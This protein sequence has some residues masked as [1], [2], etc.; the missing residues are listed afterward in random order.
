MEYRNKTA[1]KIIRILPFLLIGVVSIVSAIILAWISSG[2]VSIQ[3]WG[4]FLVVILVA[5]AIMYG[6]WLAVKS[7]ESLQLPTWLAWLIVGATLLRLIAGVLWY[8]GLPNWGYGSEVEQGGY[9]MADAYVRDT[10]AWEL[11]Q[12][13]NPLISVFGENRQIDQYGGMAF[14]SGLVYRYAG[15]DYHQPLLMIVLSASVSSLVIL[16][17]WAFVRR[18][19]GENAARL[20]AW[21]LVFF[22]DAII[23]GSSQMREA[24]LMTMVAAAFYGLVRYIQDRSRVGL[25]WLAASLLLMQPFSPPI[26]G[27][28]LLMIIFLSL[29]MDGWRLVRQTRFWIILAAIAVVVGIGIWLAWEQIAP[30][31]INNPVALIAWWFQESARWQA[32]FVKRSSQL[33][34][35]IINTTPDW[36]NMPILLGYGVLQPFL[37]GALLDQGFP[38]WKGIAIWRSIGWTIMLPFLLAAPL[39]LIRI[40]EKR[41]LAMGLAIAV[42]MGILVASFRS[43]GDLW[44]NPRYRVVFIS[45]QAGLVAWVWYSQR[46]SKNPWLWRTLLGLAIILA[47]FIP[48]YLQRSGQIIWPVN[49]VFVTLG[50]GLMSVI[51][52]FLALHWRGRDRGKIIQEDD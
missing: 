13:N 43:G 10:A 50:L 5:V 21:I 29:S 44:D 37:P 34:R 19:W 23:L 46:E 32:Y 41:K 11:A 31:G 9:I 39:L 51:I 38:V 17:S 48:W 8:I 26:T 22:P 30:A 18:L 28:F 1:S 14:L 27:V 33:I 40:K 16:F 47:W 45:L 7:D 4:Q 3:S 36:V 2:Y 20:T 6:C 52:V 35:R 42:W 49:N 24:F 15:G 12:S 25:A